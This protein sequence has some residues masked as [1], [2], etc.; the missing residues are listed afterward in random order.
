MIF[1]ISIII[2][3]LFNRIII[4]YMFSYY[5]NVIN[6]LLLTQFE[7]F[8]IIHNIQFNKIFFFYNNKFLQFHLLINWEC[9]LIIIAFELNFEIRYNMIFK[10][11]IIIIVI[12]TI[13]KLLFINLVIN[14]D[15]EINIVIDMLN[16]FFDDNIIVIYQYII[17]SIQIF[18][19]YLL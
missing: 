18:F 12:I 3:S 4:Y 6:F 8:F 19:I 5:A 1:R 2:I 9:I 13:A 15:R 14:I 16:N 11:F 7:S 10:R 17:M